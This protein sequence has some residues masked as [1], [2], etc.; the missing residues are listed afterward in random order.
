M[1]QFYFLSILLNLLAGLIILYGNG[2]SEGSEQQ[3]A[4]NAASKK[5]SA[6]VRAFGNNAFFEDKTFRLVLGILCAFVGLM[7]LVSV[8]R[9]DIPVAGDLLPAIAGMLGGTCYIIEYYCATASQ[10]PNL[11]FFVKR[12]FVEDRKY[13]GIFC[14]AAAVLHFIFPDVLLL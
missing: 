1:L 4:E 6:F 10:E 5:R 8:V 9:N 12:V 3:T 2:D 11:P 7:K 13:I 14:I